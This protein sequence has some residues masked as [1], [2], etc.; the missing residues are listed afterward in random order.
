[1]EA[2]LRILIFTHPGSRIPDP[3][4]RIQKK[5]KERGEK[6]ISCHTF[7]CSHKF[8][9]IVNYFSFEALKKKIWANFQRIIELFTKKIVKKLLKIWSWDPGSGIRD[10][11][12]VKNLFR[13]LDPGSRIQGSKSTR[14]R[15][16]DPD[17]Q[18]CMEGTF[19]SKSCIGFITGC[20]GRGEKNSG[21]RQPVF[22]PVPLRPLLWVGGWETKLLC[23]TTAA[24]QEWR[25][26]FCCT[27]DTSAPRMPRRIL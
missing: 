16:P 21:V 6:K 12:S 20:P 3:G 18:H 24:M 15:I 17:P 13:I 9:K 19:R 11:G 8:H 2:V 10:P 22:L 27:V 1:M 5:T 26:S 7:L 14:S 4:S 23:V 25:I